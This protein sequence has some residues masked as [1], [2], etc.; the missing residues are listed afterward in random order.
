MDLVR[1]QSLCNVQQR[2]KAADLA[3]LFESLPF[4]AGEAEGSVSSERSSSPAARRQETPP[5]GLVLAAPPPQRGQHYRSGQL[6]GQAQVT[7]QV[8]CVV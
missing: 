8:V 6:S 4:P 5:V 3:A 1:Q 2:H 7:Y